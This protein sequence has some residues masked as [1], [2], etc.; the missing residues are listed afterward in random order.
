MKRAGIGAILLMVAGF[1]SPAH[2]QTAGVWSVSGDKV[3]LT[4]ADN[5][6]VVTFQCNAAAGAMFVTASTGAGVAPERVTVRANN[7]TAYSVPVRVRDGVLGGSVPM[8]LVNQG[9]RRAAETLVVTMPPSDRPTII[10]DVVPQFTN[11]V[12]GCPTL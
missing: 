4:A 1:S 2:A 12:A 8:N 9:G 5:S 10:V 6:S 7:G 3:I 11:L